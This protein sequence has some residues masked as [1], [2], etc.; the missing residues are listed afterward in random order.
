M[1]PAGQSPDR[2]PPREESGGRWLWRAALGRHWKMAGLALITMAVEGAALGALAKL[3]QPMF[4]QVLVGGDTGAL[5]LVAGGVL[6]VFLLRAAATLGQ[7]LA[8]TQVS[9][10]VMAELRGKLFAHLMSLDM[11]FHHGHPPGNLIERVQGDVT[12]L[13][14]S[15]QQLAT[16]LGRDVIAVLVLFGVALSV[17]WRWTVVALAGTPLLVL[18][19]ILAQRYVRRRVREAREAAGNMSTRLDEALHG[20]AQVKLGGLEG[21]QIARFG[22]ANAEKA[23]AALRAAGG[24]AAIPGLLDI[25]SGIGFFLVLWFAGRQII[26]GERTVGEFMS[27]FAAISLAFEPL[28]RLGNLSGLWQAASASIDRVRELFS[29]EPTIRDRPEPVPGA[30][31]PEGAPEIRFEE[32]SLSYGDMPALSSV[33]FTAEAGK[34]TA[35]VG[36]SGAGKSTIF[37]VLTRLVEPQGGRVLLGGTDVTALPLAELR[38][39]FAVVTQEALLFDETIHENIA[40]GRDVPQAELAEVLEAAHVASFLPRLSHG[41]QTQAGPRGS[42]LSGGQRQRIAIARALLRDAPVLLLDE[43][44]SAL[45]TGTEALVQEAVERLSAGRT[46]L[47]IAHRLS[48]VRGAD[49]IVVMHDGRVVDEGTHEALLER[50]GRYADLYAMQFAEDTP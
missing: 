12:Q 49:R 2:R 6:G 21:Y 22:R 4:D 43:A 18:P 5:A 46:T 37:N 15:V 19:A 7:R 14:A 29:T 30:P 3:I 31:L 28:R 24:Q 34:T 13:G 39:L 41:L 26:A 25:M 10:R 33:S 20:I 45:D 11:A 40:L 48:T 23:R 27:F 38:R 35:L 9:E 42:A 17:D 1:S 36:A 47:V 44:T 8:M 50:G 16:G 32:V